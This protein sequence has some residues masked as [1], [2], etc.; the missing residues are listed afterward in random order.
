VAVKSSASSAAAVTRKLVA[1][2]AGGVALAGLKILRLAMRF[3]Y[4][5][6]GN[7]KSTCVRGITTWMLLKG[8]IREQRIKLNRPKIWAQNERR[9]IWD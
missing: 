6:L 4:C 7:S 8:I 2:V 5:K 3:R 1:V 9:S